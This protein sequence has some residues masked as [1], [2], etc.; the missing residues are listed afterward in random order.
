MKISK[1][2][3]STSILKLA[4]PIFIE[5]FLFMLMGNIDTFMLSGYSDQGVAAV[6]NANF[7][8]GTIIIIFSISAAATGIL[9]AQYLGANDRSKLSEIFALSFYLNVILSIFIMI[10]MTFFQS[11]IFK[12]VNLPKELIVDTKAYLDICAT[13]VLIPAIYMVLSTVLKSHGLTKITMYMAVVLNVLNVIGNYI[14]LYGPFGLPILGVKGVAISTVFSRGLGLAVMLY[15]V[16]K[17]LKYS[18]SPKLLRPFPKETFK[19]LI[20]YGAPTAGEPIS[21]Q[22]SQMVIFS[23]VNLLGVT[24]VTTRM[25]ASM[26]TYFTYLGC[27]AISQATQIVVGHLVGAGKED[28]AEGILMRSL[29]KAIGITLTVALLFAFFRHQLFDIFTNDPKVIA[30]GGM[31]L[32]IDIFLEMGRVLNI[33]IIGGLKAAGD[34]NF[35]VAVG[36]LSMWGIS[37]L[38]AYYFGIHLGYGLLGIWFAMGLDEVIRGIIMLT[39]WKRGNWKGK[40]VFKN[41]SN[42]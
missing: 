28:L 17:H 14:F 34:V 40:A 4:W 20:K 8:F 38:G 5:I 32:L 25:Y 26:I 42:S 36:I 10:G 3:E 27:L 35:P 6:G 33:V 39:R 19:S 18:I 1:I 11:Q 15:V 16:I 21:Y 9:F 37:T 12:W 29:R 7:I 22:L 2:D 13:F 24:V 23:Y 30:M 31:I 41:E